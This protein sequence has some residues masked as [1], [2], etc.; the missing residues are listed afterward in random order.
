[1]LV[2]GGQDRSIKIYD[3][4]EAKMVRIFDKIH[5]GK[6]AVNFII[7]LAQ[8]TKDS[9]NFSLFILF[10][11]QKMPIQHLLTTLGEINCVRWNSQGDKVASA[12]SDQT[13]Q[14]IDFKTGKAVLAGTT[15]D[16]SQFAF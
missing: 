3:R 11:N 16:E 13:V 9:K 2:A 14:L 7:Q 15:T 12:S 1:M 5:T 4:R 10:L 8:Y 6:K